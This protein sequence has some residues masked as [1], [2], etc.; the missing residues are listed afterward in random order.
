ML[1]TVADLKWALAPLADAADVALTLDMATA[2]GF[3]GTDVPVLDV[4]TP[5]GQVVRVWEEGG[6][7]FLFEVGATQEFGA[8]WAQRPKKQSQLPNVLLALSLGEFQVVNR[9][10]TVIVDGRP[11][12]LREQM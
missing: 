4:A 3:G 10:I 6:G 11:I 12:T 9:R 8:W 7:D 2:D 1:E 5:A